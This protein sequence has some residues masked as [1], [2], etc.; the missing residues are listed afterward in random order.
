MFIVAQKRVP[1]Y[2]HSKFAEEGIGSEKAEV[3]SLYLSLEL[4]VRLG[5]GTHALV[6]LCSGRDVCSCKQMVRDCSE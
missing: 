3:E 2:C 4:S 6:G 1:R 5:M